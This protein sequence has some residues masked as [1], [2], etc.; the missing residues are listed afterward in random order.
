MKLTCLKCNASLNAD[1]KGK[2][3]VG[4]CPKCGKK[5]RFPEA[6]VEYKILTQKMLCAGRGFDEENGRA[7][8]ILNA[9]ALEGWRVVGC[10]TQSVGTFAVPWFDPSAA[11]VLERPVRR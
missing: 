11:I 9:R 7:E 6:T 1:F 10:M 5:M 8:G 2:K 4:E 3:S